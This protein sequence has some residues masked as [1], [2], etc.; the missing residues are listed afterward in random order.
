MEV[1]SRLTITDN[2]LQLQY[3]QAPW[4]MGLVGKTMNKKINNETYS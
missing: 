1:T 3:C 4:L 2:L